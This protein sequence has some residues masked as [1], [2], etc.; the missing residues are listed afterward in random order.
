MMEN[1]ENKYGNEPGIFARIDT[2]MMDRK[3]VNRLM[4][5]VSYNLFKIKACFFSS[6]CLKPVVMLSEYKK[7]ES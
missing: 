1:Q 5:D 3:G 2:V 7:Y 4:Q 6:F